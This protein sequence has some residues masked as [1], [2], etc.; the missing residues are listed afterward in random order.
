MSKSLENTTPEAVNSPSHYEWCAK[1]ME[2][3]DVIEGF[4]LGFNLGNVVKYVL[5]AGK[6]GRPNRGS[7]KGSLVSQ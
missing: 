4:G 3:I 1:G 2:V 5:R 7:K 6:K